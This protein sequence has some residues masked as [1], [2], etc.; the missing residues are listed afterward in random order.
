MTGWTVGIAM[1]AEAVDAPMRRS[2]A[3]LIAAGLGT[4]GGGLGL[5]LLL[6]GRI[7]RVQTAATSAARA[8]ARGDAVPSLRSNIVEVDDLWTGLRDAKEILD[9]RLRERDAA[10]AEAD[11]HRA[12]LFTREQSARHAAEALNRAKDEFIATVS[13]ELR[14]PLNALLGWVALLKTGHLEPVRQ[15][16]AF[17]VI[18]RNS[19]AQGQLIEDLLD[20]SR[21]I[22]GVVRLDVEPIDV[23]AVLEA[24]I[25]T[26][27]PAA[28]AR[29]ISIDVDAPRGTAIVSGDRS[30]LQQMLWNV[31]SNALKFTAPGGHIDARVSVE[32]TDVMVRVRDTGE[33]IAPEFLPHVFDRFRQETSN[34][35]RTHSG[36]GLGLSLVRHLTELHGGT[37]A[38]DSDGKG[39]GA[40]F[41]IKLPQLSSR[42]VQDPNRTEKAATTC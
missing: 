8:L 31:L 23:A 39:Q 42:P 5:A 18:E 4:L 37:I 21:V 28:D 22:R 36:L 14:T 38:A 27:K 24:A 1:P 32:E 30:R 12:A 11:L 34:T 26:L 20:M 9:R 25:D 6:G 3:L 2:L 29:Q 40:T 33:G 16:H 41:T 15:A 10:Q 35:K 13:H 7:L 17:D 19:R